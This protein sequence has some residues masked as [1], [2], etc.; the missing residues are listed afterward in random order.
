[1]SY[2]IYLNQF[3]HNLSYDIQRGFIGEFLKINK[4]SLLKANLHISQNILASQIK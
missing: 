3:D 2:E 1:M 4:L